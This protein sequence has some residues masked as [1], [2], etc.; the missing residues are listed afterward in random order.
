MAMAPLREFDRRRMAEA[1][2]KPISFALPTTPGIK[3][4]TGVARVGVCVQCDRL[5]LAG[6]AITPQARRGEGGVYRCSEQVIDGVHVGS[7]DPANGGAHP[8]LD[9]ASS[10]QMQQESQC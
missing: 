1:G 8:Y 5:Y 10:N 4:C 7:V 6:E 9:S 2:T 3:A